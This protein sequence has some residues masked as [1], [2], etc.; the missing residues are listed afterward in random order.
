MFGHQLKTQV[1]VLI[2]LSG[3]ETAVFHIGERFW[4]WENGRWKNLKKISKI[5]SIL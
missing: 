5:S 4:A 3:P 2:K 1:L